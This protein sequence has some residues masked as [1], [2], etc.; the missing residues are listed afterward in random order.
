MYAGK[1]ALTHGPERVCRLDRKREPLLRGGQ[2]RVRI[3]SQPPRG[4]ARERT[5]MN[6]GLPLSP[7]W[8]VVELIWQSMSAAL[9]P[10]GGR[11]KISTSASVCCHS[12]TVRPAH[13][14]GPIQRMGTR[15]R[16]ATRISTPSCTN[17][18]RSTAIDAM[19]WEHAMEKQNNAV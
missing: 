2:K 7:S 12:Y 16:H 4:A 6:G 15:D 19:E 14:I 3:N 18:C 11:T 8:S 10:S 13:A 9:T 5:L 17:L 1:V